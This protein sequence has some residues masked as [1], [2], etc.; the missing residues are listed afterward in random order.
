MTLPEPAPHSPIENLEPGHRTAILAGLFLLAI[1]A[2]AYIVHLAATMP[3]HDLMAMPHPGAWSAG[4]TVWLAVMWVVMMIAMMLPS[5]APTI[6]LFA[7][8]A[9]QRRARGVTVVPTAAFTLGYLL[10]WAAFGI[11]AAVAQSALHS[12][13]LLSPAMR[14]A[15]PW[16]GGGLLIAAG[17]YQWLPLKAGCLRRCRS[18]LGFLTIDSSQG[19]G[20]ALVMGLRYGLACVGC[21][22]LL[23]LLLFVAGVM[24]LVWVA[25]IAGLVIVERTVPSGPAIGMLAGAA[26]AAWGVW[27]VVGS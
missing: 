9:Q 20:G 12:M 13:A 11:V 7:G 22:W 26:L 23:M 21:C 4:E 14:S 15:S 3:A 16:L 8:V 18:P 10:A 27:V 25:A 2:W 1:P 24:N 6:L 5:A 17:I 19:A